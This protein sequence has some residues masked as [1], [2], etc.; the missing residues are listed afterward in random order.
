[1]QR[2]RIGLKFGKD[3]LGCHL[4][5]VPH[6]LERFRPSHSP[7]FRVYFFVAQKAEILTFE[8]YK[9]SCVTIGFHVRIFSM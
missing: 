1:M 3:P 9:Q 7:V 2:R 6:M 8:R 5:L 4:S